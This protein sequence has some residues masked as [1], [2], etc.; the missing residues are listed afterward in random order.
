VSDSPILSR[1]KRYNG[2][3]GQMAYDVTVTYPGETPEPVTFVGSVYGGPIVMVT[4]G[5]PGG[6]FVTHPERFGPFG[7]EW[8]RRFFE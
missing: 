8:V 5:N 3:T 2:I 6:T 4:R 1:I 7:P